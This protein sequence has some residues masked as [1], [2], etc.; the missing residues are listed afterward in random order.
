VSFLDGLTDDAL[1]VEQEAFGHTWTPA[2]RIMGQ[3]RHVQHHV[4]ISYAQIRE[5]TG[6]YPEWR[7]FNE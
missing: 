3:L 6:A 4:G 2:D 5:T 1:V 7:G